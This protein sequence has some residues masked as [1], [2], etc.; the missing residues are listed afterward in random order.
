MVA[1]L[2]EE[3]A[4]V[5]GQAVEGDGAGIDQR[6]PG[7]RRG[8]RRRAFVADVVPGQAEARLAVVVL[9]RHHA[10][11]ADVAALQP[12]HAGAPDSYAVAFA[13]DLGTGDVEAQESEG[14]SVPHHGDAG[15]RPAVETADQEGAGIGGV[16]GEPIGVA[17]IPAL[18]AGPVGHARHV[19]GAGDVD[20]ELRHDA[21]PSSFPARKSADI[22]RTV[23]AP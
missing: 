9:L 4:V 8:H 3:A 20:I 14:G 16:E 7:R 17:R 11:E 19:V 10:V 2:G 18:V 15:D 22:R 23:K 13:A 21:S 12:G 5:G 6:D 1:R